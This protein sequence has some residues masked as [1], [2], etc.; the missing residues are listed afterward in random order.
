MYMASRGEVVASGKLNFQKFNFLLMC[1]T[2]WSLSSI[3]E[4]ASHRYCEHCTP[5]AD[6]QQVALVDT[7]PV[8]ITA[9]QNTNHVPSPSSKLLV[10]VD[11]DEVLASF[12]EGLA[13]FH[14]SEYGTGAITYAATTI[15]AQ[16]VCTSCPIERTIY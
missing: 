6:A 7:A 4:R 3:C 2:C 15:M 13:T 11:L 5:M 9:T 14:N 12:V 1:V 10:A 8:P 16:S